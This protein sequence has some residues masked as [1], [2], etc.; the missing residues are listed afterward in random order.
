MRSEMQDRQR[1]SEPGSVSGPGLEAEP[2]PESEPK[3]EKEK[4]LLSG[5][6]AVRS[7]ARAR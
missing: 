3:S 7:H 5:A 6:R 4:C 2:D 1:Q